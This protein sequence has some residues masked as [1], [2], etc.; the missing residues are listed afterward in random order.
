M[1]RSES[2]CPL[3]AK[4]LGLAAV[5]LCWVH[6]VPAGETA[7]DRYVAKPDPTYSWKV[8]RKT[9]GGGATQFVVDLKSQTWRTA[10][11]V[12]RPVWEHWLTIV[13]PAKPASKV[14]FLFIT[15]G[16]NGDGPPKKAELALIATLTN[17][18]VA[19]LKMVPNEPLVFNNDGVKRK[20]DDLIAYTWDKFLKGGDDNWPAR[21]PMVKSAVRAMDCVQELLASDQ[22]GKIK[23]DK[24]VVAGGSKRGWTTWCTAAVDKRVAAIIPLSIDCLNNTASMQ[25]HVAVYGFYTEAVGDYFH[26]KITARARDPRMKLLHDIEDPYS[27]RDRFTMPKFIVGGSGD[28][29]FCPDS[30]QFYYDDLPDEKLIRYIP[31]ADHSLKDSDARDSVVA[32]YWTVVTGTPRPKYS[33]TFDRD[34]SIQVRTSDR[35]KSVMLWQATNPTARDFRV[36]TIGKQGFKSTRLK[37]EGGGHY[38]AK[39]DTP[40][41]GWTASFVELAFDVGVRF[42]LKVSTAV[43]VT[44]DTLPHRDLDP[45]KAPYEIRHDRKNGKRVAAALSN[46][47]SPAIRTGVPEAAKSASSH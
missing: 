23:I 35:P 5:V 44:P 46:G 16:S 30:S 7:L 38:V 43:R 47:P 18:V 17:S 45:T 27:Y 26:H 9:E 15:G 40:K 10:K 42:T 22:G 24:F 25:H 28:Q 8:V 13:K 2:V 39:I 1:R 3:A 11:E 19:E 31:N 6:L 14:A 37:D 36:M 21:L 32:F 29:Y 12:D 20:E 34:G 41:Q 33:W 4:S